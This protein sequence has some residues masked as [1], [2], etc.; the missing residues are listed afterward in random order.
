MSKQDETNSFIYIL[1]CVVVIILFVTIFIPQI[2]RKAVESQNKTSTTSTNVHPISPTPN[3]PLLDGY[4][5]DSYTIEEITD[6]SCKVN[7]D[8]QT[9]MEYLVQSRCPFTS[10]CLEKRC[11]VVC[12]DLEIVEI[13][14]EINN[15]QSKMDGSI[16]TVENEETSYEVLVSIPNL[17]KDFAS[18][19]KKIAIGKQIR[20]LGSKIKFSNTERVIASEIYVQ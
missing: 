10:I 19:M 11:T 9:P 15:I 13:Q 6:V 1:P 5:L 7:S 17:G 3:N 12:P 18:E 16:L 4:T 8:C 14:G 20:V 2:R